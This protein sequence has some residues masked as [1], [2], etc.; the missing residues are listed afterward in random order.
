LIDPFGRYFGRQDL[1][2]LA[3]ELLAVAANAPDPSPLLA[4]AQAL[5]GVVK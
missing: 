3:R 5:L 2:R 4:A 1:E